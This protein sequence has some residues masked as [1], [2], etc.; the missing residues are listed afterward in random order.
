M[1]L[2]A[3]IVAACALAG[4]VGLLPAESQ[5]QPVRPAPPSADG[6]SHPDVPPPAAVRAT[7]DSVRLDAA[8]AVEAGV[9]EVHSDRSFAM[10]GVRWTGARPDTVEVRHRTAG[11]W[12]TWTALDPSDDQPEIRRPSSASEPLWTGP[13]HDVQVRAQ[14]AGRPVTDGLELV[15]VDPG[16]APTDARLGG[17][18]AA[19]A[20]PGMPTVVTRAQ[21]GADES[22]MTWAPEYASTTKAVAIHHTAGTNDYTCEQSAELIRGIYRYHAVTNGWGD[23]G[24]NVLVDKCGTIFEGRAGGLQYPT[25][26]AH[27]GGFNTF[28]FGISMLGTFTDVAPTDATLESVSAMAAWKLGG[29]YRNPLGVTELVSSGG[30]TARWPAGTVVTL[31]T[32]FGHRDSGFTECPG[33]VAYGLLGRIRNRVATLAEGWH[34][35]PVYAKWLE[36][37]GDGSFM[38]G[39]FRPEDTMVGDGLGTL[40]GTGNVLVAWH[41]TTGAHWLSGGIM[42]K[43]TGSGGPAALGYP[44]IDQVETP[45]RPGAAS[46][47]ANGSSI[48]YS[49]ATGPAILNGAVRQKYWELGATQST[50]GFP[51]TDTM[52]TP[53]LFG[54]FADFQG[55]VSIYAPEGGAAHWFSGALR[56]RWRDAGGLAGLGFPTSDQAPTGGVDGLYVLF[57]WNRVIIWGSATGAHLV[58]DGFLDRLRADGDVARD[59]LPKT[60]QLLLD[61]RPGSTYQHFVNATIIG[62]PQGVFSLRS[63]VRAEWWRRGGYTG[64]LGLPTDNGRYVSQYAFRQAFEGGSITCD[65]RTH[66]CV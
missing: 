7:S 23:I 49:T 31:P 25:I 41:Q 43:W 44:V 45:G 50:F 36:L 40:F 54:R 26:G 17:A 22:M 66:A 14:R 60:E 20:T 37:G 1:P 16:S 52:D 34:Q 32:I 53:T 28:T 59:G 48:Y 15:T 39:A 35:S 12:S 24:Y 46:K 38:G 4:A 29:S 51:I 6:L 65:D 11:G 13:T 63:D 56:Q 9:R 55:L 10:V 58:S 42:H 2:R 33:T 47:F 5:A 64:P 57:G 3:T 61:G 30:G 18:A 19:A 21:W 62:T 27:A 8:R